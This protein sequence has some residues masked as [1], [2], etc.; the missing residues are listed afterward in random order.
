MRS[1]SARGRAVV[2]ADADDPASLDGLAPSPELS[3]GLRPAHDRRRAFLSW[4]GFWVIGRQRKARR[5][6]MNR[7]A[8]VLSSSESVQSSAKLHCPIPYWQVAEIIFTDSTFSIG[9]AIARPAPAPPAAAAA[10]ASVPVTST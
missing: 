7:R 8:P 1:R 3:R 2:A 9:E 6:Q 5:F 4:V 10:G